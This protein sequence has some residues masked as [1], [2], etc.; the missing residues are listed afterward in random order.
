MNIME[1]IKNWINKNKW[2]TVLIAFAVVIL[3]ISLREFLFT[4][5]CPDCISG[6]ETLGQQ[7]G[8]FW[9]GAVLSSL[10]IAAI[11]HFLVKKLK[12]SGGV[13][14]GYGSLIA[15][16]VLLSIAWGKGCTDKANDGVTSGKGRVNK[17]QADPSRV[18]A[19]DLLQKK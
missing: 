1:K 13:G 14:V 12:V 17:V 8:G 2:T 7:T 3:L 18:P 9:L 5:D 15:I 4:R 11:V 10:A 16:A 19:E 6:W